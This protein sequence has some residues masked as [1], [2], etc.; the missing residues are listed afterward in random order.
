MGDSYPRKLIEVALPLREI[1][2]ASVADK[3]RKVGTIKNLHKWF[4][5]MPAPA[6]RALIFAT[7][8]NDPGEKAEREKLTKILKKLVTEDGTAPDD[9]VQE[10]AR[11][12]IAQQNPE[13]PIVLDPFCGGGSTVVEAQRLGLP[14]A[15]SDLNPVAVLITRVLGGLLPPMA[16]APAVSARFGQRSA[17]QAMLPKGTRFEGFIADLRYYGDLVQRA[18]QEKLG[19]LYPAIPQGAPVAWLWCR[20]VPCPSPMCRTPV[21]LLSS[22]VLSK[23]RGREATV[24][25]VIERK[26]I[27]FIVHKGKNAPTTST[28]VKGSRARFQCLACAEQLGEQELREAG[29]ARHLGLQLMAVCVDAPSGVGR[30]FLAAERR[31]RAASCT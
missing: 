19:D 27:R 14:V 23:Q 30:T 29:R 6:L 13:L 21:P 7:L 16:G 2:E 24:E 5:P 15:A 31:R 11:D 22:P 20:T 9:E 1:S 17:A 10:Q 4:A 12:L 18:V 3:N 8:V 28:K 25:P 26:S